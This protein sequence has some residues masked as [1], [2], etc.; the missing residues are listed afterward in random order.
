MIT[1]EYTEKIRKE[2]KSIHWLLN[3]MPPSIYNRDSVVGAIYE[4]WKE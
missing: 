4:G 1:N 3:W 2:K